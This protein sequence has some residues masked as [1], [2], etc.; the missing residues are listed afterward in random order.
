MHLGRPYSPLAVAA[1]VLAAAL[2]NAPSA[3]AQGTPPAPEVP[4]ARPSA[5]QTE[6][7]LIDLPTTL[8]IKRHRS[9][10]RLTHRFARDL[11]RGDLGELASDLFSLDNGAI[12]G[13]EY[14]FGI[15]SNIQAGVHRS[16]L[17]KTIQTFG[18][19][20]AV[21]QGERSPIGASLTVSL[22]GLD[23]MRQHLQP[24][25]AITVSRTFGDRLALYATPAFVGSTHAVDIITGHEDH[26]STPGVPDEH[27][28]HNDTWMLGMGGRLRFSKTG[29]VVGEYTPRLAGY[30]PNSG[31]WGVAV[32]K[33]TGG[34]VLQLNLTNSFGTTFGQLARGGSPHDVYLG[35]NLTRKF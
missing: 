34:H 8:S 19:W 31:T 30:D 22:E 1:F 32:E 14:R 7:N 16:M 20:D 18:R 9:Y 29:Y 10:F 33:T 13:F 12:I 6:L 15:T 4:A 21:A 11:R 3:R 5:V 24:A 27:S 23:N 28:T 2:A 17:S 35:F 26:L 25:V